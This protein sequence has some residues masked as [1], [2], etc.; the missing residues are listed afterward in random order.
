[1][2]FQKSM[3]ATEWRGPSNKSTGVHCDVDRLEAD[4]IGNIARESTNPPTTMPF[5]ISPKLYL[6]LINVHHI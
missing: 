5:V 6:T 2:F 4:G 1:M 3:S